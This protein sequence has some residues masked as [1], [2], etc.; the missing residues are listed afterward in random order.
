MKILRWLVL[1]PI[2]AFGQQQVINIGTGPNSGNGD[3]LRI[4]FTKINAN[5]TQL[6]Q[7]FGATG[8]L[9]GTGPVPS[10]LA[11]AT[12]LDVATLWSGPLTS[13]CWLNGA[14]GCTTPSGGGTV[15]TVSAAVPTGLSVSVT[16]PT[17][18]PNIV[19]TTSLS[20]PT[21]GTGAG[22]A[23]AAA[24][25][26]AGLFTGTTG[27]TYCLGTTGI[28]VLCTGGGGTPGGTNGQVQYNNSGAFGGITTSGSGNVALT[29]GPV[30]TTPNLGTPSAAVLT[31]ATGLPLSTGVTGNLPVGNLNSGTGASSSTFWRGDATWATPAGGGNVSTSGSPVQYQTSVFSGTTTVTGVAAGTSGQALVSAG[32]S[33]YPAYSSTLSDV[34]SVNG[35]TIP[36]SSTLLVNGGALG[37]PSSG[38]LTNATGLPISTGVSGLGTGIATALGVAVGTAG[39]PVV[40]GGA[41]GTPSSGT[42]TN[43]TGLP[44]ST[45][46]SGLGTGIATFLA[47]PSSANLASA[48]TGETGSGAAMF[49][50]APTMSSPIINTAATFGF[51]TGSTQCLQVNTSGVLAGSGAGCGGAPAFS[52]VTTGTN[53]TTLTMGTGG[54]LT[55]SGSGIIN[56]NEVNGATV[57]ASAALLASNGS[58]Q[59]TAIT[60]GNGLTIASATLSAT[61]AINAQSGASYTV[62]STDATKLVTFNNA[63]SIAVTLPVATSAGF[64][65]GF[66][67]DVEDLG[68][69]TVTITPTTSTINGAGNL[70]VTTNHGCSITSDG[71]NYQVSACTAVE[72]AANLAASGNGGVTGNL[73]VTNLNSG[74]GAS[75]STF[76]R[77]DA[78][79]ATPSGGSSAF[80]ALTGSTNTTAA[81]LVGTGASLGPTGTGTVTANAYSAA[82]ALTV[83]GATNINASNNAVTNIGTGTTTSAV[84]LGSATN[85]NIVNIN[86]LLDMTQGIAYSGASW[87]TNGI[88]LDIAAATFNDST[89]SGTITTEVANAFGAPTIKATTASTT[90]TN[91]ANLYLAAPL[92]GTNVTATTLY[93]LLTPG[94]IGDL[95]APAANTVVDGLVLTDQTAATAA[96]QQ[97]SPAIHLIGQGWKTTATAASQPTDWLIVNEPVQGTTNPTTTLVLRAQVNGGG[98]NTIATFGSG[99]FAGAFNSNVNASEFEPTSGACLSAGISSPAANT[100]GICANSTTAVQVAQTAMTLASGVELVP[101]T[102][103]AAAGSTPILFTAGTNN[104]TAVAGAM[105]YDGVV[106]YFT[107]TANSRGVMLDSSFEAISSAYTLTSQ[108]A[109]QKLLNGTANGQITVPVGTFEFE[110]QF[111]LT[112]MSATSGTFGFALGGTATFTQGWWATAALLPTSLGTPASPQLTYNTA[113]DTTLTT[114]GTGAE[115]AATISG[116]VRVTVAGT[117]IPEVSLTVAAA[118]VVGTNSFCRFRPVGSQAVVSVGNWN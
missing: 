96:N 98:Y 85:S 37:T 79:W 29:T 63:S 69:G 56:A 33:A 66:A 5:E 15:T 105:E 52:A 42:A 9:K 65:G 58:S 1:L 16:S 61:Q 114:A 83:T 107:P 14:G 82:T 59:A 20:G 74:T 62:L 101:S 25:D 73:P 6:Y 110:C 94:I 35:T 51:I 97:Y 32:T 60:L 13:G 93:S 49:G 111:S 26:I 12:Y 77:G 8:L 17:S 54:T 84:T 90:I 50:T 109:A 92:A 28:T 27:S 116:V 18:T 102:G 3:P 106:P 71:T 11:S 7:Q 87:T 76:W 36:A 34:T 91:L 108:T 89:G 113:A 115:G 40:N 41:L 80:S 88:G 48:V 53:A 47:T 24:S 68:A 38:T 22:F 72:P 64:T 117:I 43:L 44:I 104:T 19:I 55:T 10:A 46:V 2:I 118:A 75:S 86:G 103:A 99:T 39:A 21:K 100:T 81:M 31:S 30:F 70:V 112:S 78:T 67:F 95:Q 4:A 23:N 57:P 45:G